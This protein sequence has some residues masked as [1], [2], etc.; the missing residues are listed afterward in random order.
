MKTAS[1]RGRDGSAG[2][3]ILVDQKFKGIWA[4]AATSLAA[5]NIEPALI[6]FASGMRDRYRA[7]FTNIA[8]ALSEL[9]S[10]PPVI[11]PTSLSVSHES[12]AEYFVVASQNGQNYGYYLYFSQGA[13]G[14]WRI[15]S[16]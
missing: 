8:S 16:F 6:N 3:P 7:V 9:F 5:G 13:D 10:S 15:Q 4:N 11:H 14:V 1:A 12:D 2:F